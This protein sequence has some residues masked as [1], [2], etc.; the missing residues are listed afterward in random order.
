MSGETAG[1]RRSRATPCSV[2]SRTYEEAPISF[3]QWLPQRRR[4]IKGWIQTILVC[5]G[6]DIPASLGL[7]PREQLAVHGIM[8]AGVVGLLLY[9]LS[10]VAFF[11]TGWALAHGEVPEG[12][13][14][15]A[16][17]ALNCGNIVIVLIASALSAWRGLGL[18][19]ARRLAWWIPALPVYW[20]LMSL[21]AWQALFQFF[22][23]PA[24]W[25]KTEHGLARDRRTPAAGEL[26]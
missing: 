24:R 25:E 2:F 13:G 18:A 3:R 22:K 8:T 14:L 23:E 16:V 4:W 17:L 6:R 12:A 10:F 11:A 19:R 15:K 20:L 21:A 26:L 9:P 5:L 1:V 7:S